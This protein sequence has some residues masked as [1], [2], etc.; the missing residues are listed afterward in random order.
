M[1]SCSSRSAGSLTSTTVTSLAGSRARLYAALRP[2]WP[3][4]RISIF[5]LAPLHRLEPG[6]ADHQPFSTLVLKINMDTRVRALAFQV[7]YDPLAEFTM[8]H[9]RAEPDPARRRFG[10]ILEQAAAVCGRPGG[11][12]AALERRGSRARQ[13]NSRAHFLEQRRRQFLDEARGDVVA[14]DAVQ[15]ALLGI[16]QVQLAHRAGDAD[17][18]EAPLFL[19]TREVRDRALVRKQAVFHAAQEH[20]WKL[21][22]LGGVQR[23][24]LHAVFP[25]APLGLA[26]LQHR[27]RKEALQR[28]QVVGL[29]LVAA[30][31]ADQF[32]EILD[33]RLAPIALLLAVML[34]Q[35]AVVDHVINLLVQRQALDVARQSLDQRQEP[36]E[37]WRAARTTVRIAQHGAGRA[38]QRTAGAFRRFAQHIEGARADAAHRQVDDTLKRAVVIAIG[39]QAQVGKRIL[40]FRALE[41]PQA[42]VH[43]VGE[44]GLDQRFLE[45]ARLRVGAVQDRAFAPQAAARQPLLD[46]AEHEVGL[47]ALVVGTV[48]PHRFAACAAGPQLFAE[49]GRVVG[50]QR[51]RRIQYRRARAVVL[52]QLVE[53]RLRKVA[54]EFL[55]VLDLGATPAIYRLVVIANHERVAAGADQ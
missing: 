1:R 55:Q 34:D 15:A 26:G 5:M 21:Q 51:V 46:A 4:P 29:G 19:E 17:V 54:A 40:D 47:V 39:D 33:A 11:V 38:P 41:K 35:T 50:D 44:L 7:E 8:A 45:H 52:F 32:R 22:P 9:A 2:T 18:T 12:R 6:D 53:R 49:A 24:H 10:R 27:V 43:F 20:H 48:D 30:R 25:F 28:R 3:T 13:L 23:H 37:R 31:R 42:A 36:A 14:V 16:A